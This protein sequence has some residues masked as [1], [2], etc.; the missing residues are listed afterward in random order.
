MGCSLETPGKGKDE[1]PCHCSFAIS[2]P[3]LRINFTSCFI[4]IMGGKSWTLNSPKWGKSSRS[5]LSLEQVSPLKDFAIT[6][7]MVTIQNFGVS[8]TFI[9]SEKGHQD[10]WNLALG[11]TVKPSSPP[12][13]YWNKNVLALG[14]PV[15]EREGRLA[16]VT[17]RRWRN[18]FYWS[19]CHKVLVCGAY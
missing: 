5:H 13:L 16:A 11:D 9:P 14:P 15:H 6:T 4:D 19:V 8:C 10:I 7:V 2:V 3:L 18:P 17:L 1:F 12:L